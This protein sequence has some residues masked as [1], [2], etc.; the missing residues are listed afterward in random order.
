MPSGPAKCAGA[1]QKPM[2]LACDY[3]REQGVLQDIRVVMVQP[4]PTVYGVP[5]VDEELNRKIAD[6]GI[7]LRLNSEV[8]AADPL[9]QT[10]LIRDN[11]TGLH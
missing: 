8:T 11:A 10:V 3:W 4:Y 7:E 5:G 2:Y 6:Y 1:A 9:A